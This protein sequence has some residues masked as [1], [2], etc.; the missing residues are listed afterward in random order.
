MKYFSNKITRSYT[1]TLGDFNIVDLTSYYV[2][3]DSQFK[4]TNL[5][6]DNTETLIESSQKFYGD[7]DSF[8]MFL[9]ANKK[10]NPFELL[11]QNN[12]SLKNEISNL[13]G[14]KIQQ[15]GVPDYNDGILTPGSL[16]FPATEV[17]GAPWNYGSTGNFSLTGGFALID[18]FNN[19]SKRTI[20]KNAVGFTLAADVNVYMSALIKGTT[21]YYLYNFTRNGYTGPIYVAS[22][23]K[24]LSVVNEIDYKTSEKI[25]Y[26]K[27]TS[28]YPLIKKG[29]GTP[30]YEI[31]TA[32]ITQDIDVNTTIENKINTIEAYLPSTIL[33]SS[34]RRINQNYR[35]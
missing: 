33:F 18:G 5:R 10:I 14:L 6:V 28:E 9:F 31:S 26:A 16:L 22:K 3:N 27:V 12:T 15:Q 25:T 17:T 13:N 2:V 32:G 29:F 30:G 19:F 34:F 8:W 24:V 20:S 4:K 11:E 21:G 1:T 7:I 35:V 23:E